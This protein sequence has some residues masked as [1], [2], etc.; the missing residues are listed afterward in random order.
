MALC[1]KCGKEFDK[2]TGKSRYLCDRCS[3]LEQVV[4]DNKREESAIVEIHPEHD[5]GCVH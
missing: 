5:R 4:Q 2:E 3:E 1:E